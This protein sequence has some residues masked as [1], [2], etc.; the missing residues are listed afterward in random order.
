MEILRMATV[1]QRK[2]RVLSSSRLTKWM[3]AYSWEC[4]GLQ[5]GMFIVSICPL[6]ENIL[7][8]MDRGTFINGLL[9]NKG[10]VAR[11]RAGY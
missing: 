6:N 10:G 3:A 9:A 4:N 8:R 2:Q 11:G 1:Y 7:E 5:I